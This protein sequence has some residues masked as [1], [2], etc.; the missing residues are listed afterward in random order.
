[1][2]ELAA[3]SREKTAE[4]IVRSASTSRTKAIGDRR[5]SGIRRSRTTE[6]VHTASRSPAAMYAGAMKGVRKAKRR[7]RAKAIRRSDTRSAIG[8]QRPAASEP[9]RASSMSMTG[10]SDTIGYTRSACFE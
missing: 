2:P 3:G 4:A 9:G 1:M 6:A 7:R 5:L 8:A 10:M